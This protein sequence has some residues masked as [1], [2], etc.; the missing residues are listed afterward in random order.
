MNLKLELRQGVDSLH[1]DYRWSWVQLQA[2]TGTHTHDGPQEGDELDGLSLG[3][4][5]CRWSNPSTRKGKNK[6]HKA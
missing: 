3:D 6:L 4:P 5:F 2:P 1:S